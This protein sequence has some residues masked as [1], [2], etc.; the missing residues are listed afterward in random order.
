[1]L[2][3]LIQAGGPEAVAAQSRFLRANLRFV[4]SIAYQFARR[5]VGLELEDMIQEGNLGLIHALGKFDPERGFKFSTYASWWIKQSIQRAIDI[6][7]GDIRIPVYQGEFRSRVAQ[8]TRHF[9]QRHGR[10]PTEDELVDWTG[11]SPHH[12]RGIT[13]LPSANVSVD[14]P[15]QGEGHTLRGATLHDEDH[16]DAEMQVMRD[17]SME[18]VEALLAGLHP[19]DAHLIHMRYVD[20]FSLEEIGDVVGLTRE[21]VRQLLL[22]SLHLLRKQTCRADHL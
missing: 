15:L 11:L 22:K 2:A 10:D 8:V 16:I 21:R 12:I 9:V 5:G 18:A 19:R 14:D 6:Q 3:R 1:M 4:T 13:T 7:A 20:G 17:D